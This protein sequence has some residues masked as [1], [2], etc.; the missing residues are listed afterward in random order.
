MLGNKMVA[1]R[2]FLP[3]QDYN[4]IDAGKN[5]RNSLAHEAQLLSKTQCLM[6]IDGID[7]ELQAWGVL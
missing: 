5:A 7:R 3:W 6:F 1:S 4:T 2:A